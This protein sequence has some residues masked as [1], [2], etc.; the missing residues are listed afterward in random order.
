ML[1]FAAGFPSGGLFRAGYLAAFGVDFL[2]VIRSF[3][4]VALASISAANKQDIFSGITSRLW[5]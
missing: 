3:L 1:I 2:A 4:A 5:L